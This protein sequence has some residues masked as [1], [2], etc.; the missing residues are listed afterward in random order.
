M[1]KRYGLRYRIFMAFTL[2]GA[3]LGLFLGSILYIYLREIEDEVLK[4][5]QEAERDAFFKRLQ[6]DPLA[7]P[8]ASEL[9]KGYL[10]PDA[11]PP[12]LASMSRGLGPGFYEF[13]ER[14]YHLLI[15]Q[16][17]GRQEL[18]FLFHDVERTEPME[19]NLSLQVI[20]M[21]IIGMI[22]VNAW[23]GRMIAKRLIAP[24]TALAEQVRHTN[25]NQ[26]PKQ[27]DGPYSDD[28]VGVLRDVLQ[29]SMGRIARFIDREQR[30]TRDASHE[31]RTPVTAAR[32]ALELVQK[33]LQQGL[34]VKEQLGRINRAVNNMENIIETFLYLS[35]EGTGT[36]EPESCDLAEMAR[37]VAAQ[38]AYLLEGKHVEVQFEETSPCLVRAPKSVLSIAIGNLIRNAFQYTD[39][40]FVRICCEQGRFEISDTGP[41]IREDLQKKVLQREVRGEESHGFGLGLSI[42]G[43]V[44]RRYGW[45]LTLQSQAG[46][47]TT[48]RLKISR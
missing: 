1:N 38:N 21:I 6:E 8:P 40:G 14:E 44:C 15:S 22:L 35:R 36:P 30:F 28:E 20:L 23:F 32:G 37:T 11:I 18:F 45:Q 42:L 16:V 10:G 26:L 41:G 2:S 3:I 39:V 46:K 29:Q 31:L 17:P 13:E 7:S 5:H 12:D 43:E 9:F 24:L 33:R 19:Y 4:F 34:P 47:G 25:P 48:A 27:L